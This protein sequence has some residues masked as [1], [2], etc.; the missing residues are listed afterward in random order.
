Q[1]LLP[2]P[3]STFLRD[4]A[5]TPTGKRISYPQRGM[6]AN[7]SGV[8]VDPAKWDSLDGYSP[9]TMGMVDF[10]QGVD[11][12]LSNVPSLVNYAA[13]VD[14]ASPTIL[15]DADTGE[16]IEH[17]GEDD[18]SIAPNNLPVAPPKQLF[19][20]RPGRRLKNGGHYIVA[21]RNLV[22]VG[23]APLQ[24]EAA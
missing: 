11:L 15:L 21:L 22:A 23:G 2:F 17:F 18:V 14:P 3:S 12:A 24:A 6:P 1:C 20:L 7:N 4:D 9:G 16:R 8:H 10:P 19:L 5:S 13:S